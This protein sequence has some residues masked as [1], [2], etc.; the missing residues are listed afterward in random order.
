M[1]VVCMSL[2]VVCVCVGSGGVVCVC[3]GMVVRVHTRVH[4][5]AGGL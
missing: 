3:V 1:C 4:G 5:G 2:L